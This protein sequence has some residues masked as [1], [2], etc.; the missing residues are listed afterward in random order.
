MISK[1]CI[2]NWLS[3]RLND[4]GRHHNVT[5]FTGSIGLGGFMVS[6]ITYN[7]RIEHG[8]FRQALRLGILGASF[9]LAC[10]DRLV[11]V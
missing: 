1:P 9:T 7:V 3:G 2:G 8:V 5:N 4:A 6:T 10:K 11:R